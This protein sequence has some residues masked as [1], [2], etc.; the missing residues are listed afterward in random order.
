LETIFVMGK[1]FEA[2]FEANMDRH[3]GE[4]DNEEDRRPRRKNTQVICQ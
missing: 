1:D 2:S 4:K 3:L